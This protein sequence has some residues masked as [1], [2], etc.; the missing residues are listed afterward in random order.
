MRDLRGELLD[1]LVNFLHPI[2][3]THLGYIGDSL[4]DLE[5][6]L[7]LVGVARHLAQLRDQQ[8]NFGSTTSHGLVGRLDDQQWLLQVGNRLVISLIITRT[9]N[10]HQEKYSFYEYSTKGQS[11][12]LFW[13]KPE[14]RLMKCSFSPV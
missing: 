8:D 11:R 2:G 10:S 1:I 7:N 5:V 4:H 9:C 3:N 6:G 12:K 13:T 14:S